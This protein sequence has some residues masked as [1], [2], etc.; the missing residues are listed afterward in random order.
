MFA[1][2][3]YSSITSY[4]HGLVLAPMAGSTDSAFRRICRSMGATSVVTEMVAAAGLS[5]RSVKTKKLLQYDPEEKPIGV[6]LFGSRPDD[7]AR[8]SSL[9]SEL[10]FDF[11]DINAGCPVKKVL[12]S[13]SGSALL[14]DI[15]KLAAIVRAVSSETD[16]PVTVKIRTGWSPEEPVP[17]SLPAILA[18]EGAAAI[19]VHGRYRSDM[20]SGKVRAL[21]IKRIVNCSPVPVIANGDV[22]NVEA[23]NDLKIST[24][25]SGLMIGRGTLGNPWIFRSISGRPEDAVPVPGELASVIIRQFEMMKEYIPLEHVYHI[26]RGHLLHYLKGFRGASGLRRKA[27]HVENLADLNSILA[28]AEEL[29]RMER[30]DRS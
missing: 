13:G 22:I 9:V 14:R 15:P 4:T 3:D 17:D 5:R 25:A 26:L 1:S 8:A 21:E 7:F 19:A 23:A 20:F 12:R 6:Q 2:M 28:E 24:G 16:I 30:I 27:V 29:L 10:G 11:I 18:D